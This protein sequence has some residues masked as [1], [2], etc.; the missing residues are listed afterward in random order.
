[1]SFSVG[2]VVIWVENDLRLYKVIADRQIP[3]DR[4]YKNLPPLFPDEGKDY[5]ITELREIEGK[6][7]TVAFVS[8]LA[9]EL[10][11]LHD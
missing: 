5:L 8:V 3:R 11:K 9:S 1:M 10:Q 7:E 6:D 2:E 4:S